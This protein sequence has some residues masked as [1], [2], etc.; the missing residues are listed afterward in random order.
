MLLKK[1]KHAHKVYMHT[2]KI[3]MH[4]QILEVGEN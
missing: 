3:S 4:T 2:Y 1:A